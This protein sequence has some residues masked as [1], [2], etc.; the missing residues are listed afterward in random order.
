MKRLMALVVILTIAAGSVFAGGGQE[1]GGG[2]EEGPRRLVVWSHAVHQQVA[3]GTRGG[4]AINIEAEFEE[5]F[6]VEVEWNTLPFTG[7]QDQILRQVNLPR[8]EADIVFIVESWANETLLSQFESIDGFMAASPVVDAD[9]IPQGIWDT[10]AVDG[11]QKAVP[12]RSA[13]QILHYNR[14]MLE[15]LGFDGPPQSMEELGEYARAL[16]RTREDGAQIYGLGIKQWEDPIA[17]IRSFGGEV[18]SPQFEVM[19]TEPEAIEA[20]TFLRDLYADGVIPPDFAQLEDVDWQNL[21]CEGLVGMIFHGDSYYVRLSDPEQCGNAGDGWFSYIPAAESMAQEV[22]PAKIA[23]WGAGIPLNSPDEN[24]ELAYEFLRFFASPDAQLAMAL[25]GNGPVR[26]ST[27]LEPA[28]AQNIA[29]AEVDATMLPY[30]RPHLP[31]FEGTQEVFDTFEEQA[32]LAIT[33]RKSVEQAMSDAAESI[34]AI[35]RRE[36]VRR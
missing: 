14:A 27:Y 7:M 22:A 23:F 31:A 25:N 34:E 30:S 16:T 15:E 9:D 4:E 2:A 17:V 10:F 11:E 33:G 35:L 32:I 36:G 6:N 18:L 12:Y 29:Y 20:M 24:K 19:T 5:Q 13:P 26:A 8:G 1:D 21:F 3:D 28:F